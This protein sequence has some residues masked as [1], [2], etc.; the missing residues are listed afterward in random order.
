MSFSKDFIKAEQQI[1]TNL[2]A[3]GGPTN[4]LDWFCEGKPLEEDQLFKKV[5]H[6]HNLI[7]DKM[8][9]MGIDHQSF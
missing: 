4:A 1:I 5:E 9:S 6:F 3:E 2:K 8:A 7:L